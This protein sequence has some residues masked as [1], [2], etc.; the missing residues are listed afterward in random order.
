MSQFE[1]LISWD[2][3]KF[4]IADWNLFDGFSQ[5]LSL[6]FAIAQHMSLDLPSLVLVVLT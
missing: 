3:L 4:G 2:K 1:Y 5:F 6:T